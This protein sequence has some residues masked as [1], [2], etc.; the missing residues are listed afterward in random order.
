[1][2]CLTTNFS[3][4]SAVINCL[5][6]NTCLATIGLVD[7]NMAEVD[8]SPFAKKTGPNMRFFAADKDRVFEIW[9][10]GLL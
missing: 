5:L 4:C 7:E 8:I 1:M 6:A 3:L 9:S 2:P 10:I